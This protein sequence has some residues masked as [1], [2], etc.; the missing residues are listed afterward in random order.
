MKDN[1]SAHSAQYLQFRPNYPTELFDFLKSLRTDF[2]TAWDCG[3]GNGQLAV[4][5]AKFF[6]KVYATDL[7]EK[8]IAN[9]ILR[10]NIVYKKNMR[11]T[12]VLKISSSI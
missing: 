9:A 5:L 7:S 8:Q 3:T 1:F 6:D 2:K 10:D 12:R 4:C 11:N